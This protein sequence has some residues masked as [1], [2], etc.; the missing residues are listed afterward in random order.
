MMMKRIHV[1]SPLNK[2]R[3]HIIGCLL[4][5]ADGRCGRLSISFYAAVSGWCKTGFVK[6]ENIFG[7]L[8]KSGCV[9]Y[10]KSV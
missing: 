8:E 4:S 10:S 3:R 6:M 9:C 5:L 1:Q 7:M 2:L